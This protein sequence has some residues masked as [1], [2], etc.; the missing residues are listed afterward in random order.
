[1]FKEVIFRPIVTFTEEFQEDLEPK[2]AVVQNL[3][4]DVMTTMGTPNWLQLA[5]SGQHGTLCNATSVDR[6]S[7]AG[8]TPLQNEW[9]RRYTRPSIA[10]N[11]PLWAEQLPE[12]FSLEYLLSHVLENN[13]D[14]T[15]VGWDKAYEIGV[16]QRFEEPDSD[17][18]SEYEG[19]LSNKEAA[20]RLKGKVLGIKESD[21]EIYDEESVN[22]FKQYKSRVCKERDKGRIRTNGIKGKGCLYDPV[23]LEALALRI[24]DKKTDDLDDEPDLG[25][26]RKGNASNHSDGGVNNHSGYHGA[27]LKF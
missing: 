4:D 21:E 25:Y 5:L 9:I 18:P 27:K 15:D 26:R 3:H 22:I 11:L 2:D 13:W 12:N 19:W 8:L 16:A 14:L 6:K 1:M 23:G 17:A 10:V 7:I 20:V 24:R